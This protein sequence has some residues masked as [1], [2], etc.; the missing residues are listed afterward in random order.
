MKL[1]ESSANFQFF[2]SNVP[3]LVKNQK[4][5]KFIVLLLYKAG[6]LKLFLYCDPVLLFPKFGD[7]R[8]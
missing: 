6:V 4:V 7:P 1:R 8:V 3:G 5:F 2:A